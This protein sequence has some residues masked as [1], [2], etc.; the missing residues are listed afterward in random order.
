MSL[1]ESIR[2]ELVKVFTEP[3]AEV[4]A[5]CVVRAHDTLATRADMHDVRV[6]LTELTEAQKEASAELKGLAGA[7]S[8]LAVAQRKTD[9]TVAELAD[10]QK[11]T[12][13]E[14]K[15]LAGTVAE[16]TDSVRTLSIRTDQTAG[17]ALEWLVGKHLPAYLGR[18][19][20]RCRI[21]G[22]LDVIEPMEERLLQRTLFPETVASGAEAAVGGEL[23][24]GE[25]SAA[26]LDDLRRV[27]LIATGMVATGKMTAGVMETTQLYLVGE[28][29]YK[30]GN[31]DLLRASRRAALLRKAG[32]QAQAFVACDAIDA[33]VANLARRDD[34]WIIVRG[35]LLTP[36]A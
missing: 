28:V 30:A 3:Q 27:D 12:S 14:L 15:G 26:E 35:R 33:Y 19:I 23:S 24:A 2:D 4:L 31:D 32:F 17:W 20:R 34:V 18:Q 9:T 21:V 8:E 5:H 13:A 1:A 7:V 10:Q 16:L 25:L 11:E 36:A 22:I 6:A 29:S